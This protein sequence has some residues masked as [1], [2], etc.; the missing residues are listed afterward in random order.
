MRGW[1]RFFETGLGGK[2]MK[3]K[4]YILVAMTT[5][6][7]ITLPCFEFA[8]IGVMILPWVMRQWSR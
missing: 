4:V 2:T 6:R 3:T 1:F 8:C 5:N 7:R